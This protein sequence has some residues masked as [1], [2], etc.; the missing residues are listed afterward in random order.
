MYKGNIIF[1]VVVVKV[2]NFIGVIY[3]NLGKG[4]F[5]GVKGV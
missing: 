4:L 3:R 1:F 2:M 5:I